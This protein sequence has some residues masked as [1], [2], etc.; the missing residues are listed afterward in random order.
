VNLWPVCGQGCSRLADWQTGQESDPV[1]TENV[2]S[3]ISQKRIIPR[4]F[5]H[6]VLLTNMVKGT[7]LPF[8]NHN[9]DTM[10]YEGDV[11]LRIDTEGHCELGTA[12]EIT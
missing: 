6:A 4:V 1:I 8:M 10:T 11:T 2:Q 5:V 12:E 3:A 7:K 9:N